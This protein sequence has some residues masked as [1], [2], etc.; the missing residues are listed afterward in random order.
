MSCWQSPSDPLTNTFRGCRGNPS[1]ASLTQ[2]ILLGR[3]A[4]L[5]SQ[6]PYGTSLQAGPLLTNTFTEN[7]SSAFPSSFQSLLW[8]LKGSYMGT[9]G[10]VYKCPM[11][12]GRQ[13][14]IVW[15]TV[16]CLILEF[17]RE[18]KRCWWDTPAAFLHGCQST[19][20]GHTGTQNPPEAEPSPEPQSL[21]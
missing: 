16:S 5:S 11:C 3:A 20:K 13:K 10:T 18:N 15:R 9:P 2:H 14:V 17:M 4:Q 19:G 7:P 21:G 12:E 6:T 1:C 8:N